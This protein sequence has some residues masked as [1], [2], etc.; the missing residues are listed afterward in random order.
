MK[1]A[2]T[3]A[4]GWKNDDTY[5]IRVSIYP[6]PPTK[7]GRFMIATAEPVPSS[8]PDPL[9]TSDGR[10]IV[11]FPS[12]HPPPYARV[13]GIHHRCGAVTIEAWGKGLTVNAE[14]ADY[15]TQD[16]VRHRLVAFFTL[17]M[18]SP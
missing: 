12:Y 17:S 13:F 11:F 16:T 14:P 9:F 8:N 3:E 18:R 4:I 1:A 15:R 10:Y 5:L 6:T 2:L 7:I